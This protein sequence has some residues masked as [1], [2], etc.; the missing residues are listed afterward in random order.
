MRAA[1]FPHHETDLGHRALLVLPLL[2]PAPS[3]YGCGSCC[4]SVWHGEK[5]LY[6]FKLLL[7]P[8]VDTCVRLAAFLFHCLLLCCSDTPLVDRFA[9]K[10]PEWQAATTSIIH[11]H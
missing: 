8:V 1:S 11:T 9:S 6:V 4:V 3:M 7:I 2:P 5:P 10:W